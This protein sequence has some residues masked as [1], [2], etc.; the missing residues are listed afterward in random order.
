MKAIHVVASSDVSVYGLNRIQ[1]TTD[2][3]LGLPVGA[4]GT[5]YV[6]LGYGTGQGAEA[7]IVA[8]ANDTHVTDLPDRSAGWPPG[9]ARRSM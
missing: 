3:Y 2:A 5:D 1:Y 9:R 8:T 4:L 7:S 6:V